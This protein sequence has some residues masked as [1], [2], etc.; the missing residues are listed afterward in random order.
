MCHVALGALDQQTLNVSPRQHHNIHRVAA[1]DADGAG[2]DAAAGGDDTGGAA[3]A[4]VS[5]ASGW[6]SGVEF[7]VK[8]RRLSY[9]HTSW[10]PLDSLRDL[11]GFKRVLNY[12]K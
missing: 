10:Q 5:P 3:A 7:H 2:D 12:I 8:W 9:I 4:A 6:S 11:P 1:A